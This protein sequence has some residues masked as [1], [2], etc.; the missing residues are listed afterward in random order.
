MSDRGDPFPVGERLVQDLTGTRAKADKVAVLFGVRPSPTTQV[1]L[2]NV[3]TVV[4]G[5]ADDEQRCWATLLT[6]APGCVHYTAP[7]VIIAALPGRADPLRR[8]RPGDLIGMLAIDMPKRHRF[9]ING[10]VW[11]WGS[12]SLRIAVDRVYGNCAKY[13]NTGALRDPLLGNRQVTGRG[14]ELTAAQQG[15]IRAGLSPVRVASVRAGCPS[16]GFD[17]G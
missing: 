6:D 8:C 3:R 7:V 14:E 15:W 9:R 2:S 1:F 11:Q 5:G 13:I 4:L 17:H 10:R 12:E 16:G